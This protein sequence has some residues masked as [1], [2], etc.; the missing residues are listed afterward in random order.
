MEMA[1]GA[2]PVALLQ[3]LVLRSLGGFSSR[4]AGIW[5]ASSV[6]AAAVAVPAT[7]MWYE[8]GASRLPTW[9]L[10]NNNLLDLFMA[11]DRWI[12]ALLLGIAQGLVLASVLRHQA[13]MAVWAAVNV[14][15]IGVAPYVRLAA[16]PAGLIGPPPSPAAMAVSAVELWV[17]FA[18]I[19]GAM[20]VVMS[21]RWGLLK[22]PAPAARS[23]PAPRP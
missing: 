12:Y 1:L 20:L 14:L 19:T 23:L 3:Y 9:M 5:A 2:T 18:A 10:T 21:V 15:A 4:A 22:E 16:T 17:P 7:L 13:V 6:L 8:Q 11:G